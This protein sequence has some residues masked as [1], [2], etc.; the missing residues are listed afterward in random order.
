[1]V[2]RGRSGGIWGGWLAGN[3]GSLPFAVIDY[4]YDEL[5][6]GR[7]V[8]F[9]E[10]EKILEA[11]ESILGGRRQVLLVEGAT[12]SGQ[13]FSEF[14]NRFAIQTSEWELRTAVLYKNSTVPFEID[15]V[16]RD[17]LKPWPDKF[18]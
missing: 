13:T 5:P 12:S 6:D 17:D 7:T 3:L 2:G 8:I 18:P 10:G 11:I 9:P 15:Y 4:T 16:G 1:V 14:R